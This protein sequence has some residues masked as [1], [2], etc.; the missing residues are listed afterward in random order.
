MTRRQIWFALLALALGGFGIGAT[1]FASMGL[2]PEITRDLLPN[3]YAIHPDQALGKSSLM[4]TSYAVGVVLGAP[5]LAVLTAKISY[6]AALVGFA[7]SF[8]VFT[9]VSALAPTFEIALIARFL[10]A[11]PHGAYFGVAPIVA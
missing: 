8:T 2:L 3:L 6:R 7:A 4:I 1:E 9:V 5:L 11:V 10:A